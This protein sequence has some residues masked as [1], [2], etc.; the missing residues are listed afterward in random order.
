M[1][2]HKAVLDGIQA[3]AKRL[4]PAGDGKPRFMVMRDSLVERD[5]ELA[6]QKKPTCLEEEPDVYV[7]KVGPDGKPLAKEAPVK[8]NDHALDPSRYLV[9]R[10]DLRP[11]SVGYSQRVY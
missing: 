7:W 1:N 2:A 4:K 10:F 3:T 6:Q 9:A 11:L 8:E 5:P